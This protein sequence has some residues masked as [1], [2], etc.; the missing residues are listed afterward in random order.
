MKRKIIIFWCCCSWKVINKKYRKLHKCFLPIALR[1]KAYIENLNT[2]MWPVASKWTCWRYDS[3]LSYWYQFTGLYL[4]TVFADNMS[5][6]TSR[7]FWRDGSHMRSNSFYKRLKWKNVWS[8]FA[9]LRALWCVPAF[10]GHPVLKIS[11]LN[12][13]I[14]LCVKL[15]CL[16]WFKH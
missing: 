10:M 12:W 6:N 3:K 14:K 11:L 13:F 7:H 4:K 2:N 16:R 1:F 5:A 8:C 9:V 15:F